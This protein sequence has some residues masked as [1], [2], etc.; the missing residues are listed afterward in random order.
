[1][2]LGRAGRWARRERPDGAPCYLRCS[3]SN[4][5][6]NLHRSYFSP[7]VALMVA[8]I[9]FSSVEVSLFPSQLVDVE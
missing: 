8:V 2:D 6:T 7:N 1:M 4:A 3:V 9:V 5:A